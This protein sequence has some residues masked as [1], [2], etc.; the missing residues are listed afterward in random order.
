MAKARRIRL[1]NIRIAKLEPAT[2]EY[3]VWD[4]RIGGL[5]VRVRPSGHRGY[6][7][8]RMVDGRVKKISLGPAAL[9]SIE[10][11]RRE[12]L[13]IEVVSP[14]A[15]PD[16]AGDDRGKVPTLVEFVDGGWKADRYDRYRQSTRK[17]VDSE[18]RT[19]LLPTFGSLPLDRIT[20]V[21]VQRWFDRYSRTAPG[22]ANHALKTLRGI[23]N[24][25]V[26]CGHITA[27]PVRGVTRNLRPRLTR[28]L[29]RA[30]IRRLH[31]V[32]DGYAETSPSGRQQADIIR[33]LLLTGCRKSEIV[34]LRWQEVNGDVLN[35]KDSKTGPRTVFL[36][37][38]ARIIIERQPRQESVFVFPSPRNPLRPRGDNLP[39]WY[40]VR[41]RA[42][43]QDV[44]LHDLRHTFASQA[45]MQGIPV[46]VV[47]RL[48]GH[49]QLRMTLRYAH[50]ADR[51]IEAAAERIGE[52]INGVMKNGFH[53]EK[54]PYRIDMNP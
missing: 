7:Y 42:G 12:A 28:F 26:S 22:G 17:S 36:N 35:L 2:H 50:I 45:V 53:E 9:K 47:A 4:T 3:T 44:R 51:E 39:L 29:S 34:N 54:R 15:G 23:L 16:T 1:T 19:Q 38:Q 48:L 8:Y 13:E 21:A 46:P 30:E 11:V 18:L 40:R 33:L 32:L 49:K 14:I 43:I 31:R 6:V 41:K 25:A 10:E 27:S 20:R 52:A 5:G 24:H 37:A